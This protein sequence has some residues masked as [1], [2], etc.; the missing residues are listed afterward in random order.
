M[1]TS[2]LSTKAVGL[3]VEHYSIARMSY[4][5]VG[6]N[7]LVFTGTNLTEFLGELFIQTATLHLKTRFTLLLLSNETEYGIIIYC[8]V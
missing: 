8:T 3:S 1:P 2:P 7:D 6:V 4:V 5:E